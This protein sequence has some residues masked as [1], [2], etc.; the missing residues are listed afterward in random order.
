MHG[1]GRGS[2]GLY[3]AEFFAPK[4]SAGQP[5]RRNRPPGAIGASC[6]LAKINALPNAPAFMIHT[7]DLSHLA[8]PE[9]FDTLEQILKGCK[10]RQVFYVPGEHDVLN[11][12]G[13]Q[14]RER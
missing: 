3:P 10:T 5:K 4:P 1:L 9:E 11:D 8:E 13:K 14:Y 12:N 7:G 2:F 6:R